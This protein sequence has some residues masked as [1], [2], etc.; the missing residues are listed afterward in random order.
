MKKKGFDFRTGEV[1]RRVEKVSTG[2]ITVRENAVSDRPRG[3]KLPEHETQ[4]AA[5]RVEANFS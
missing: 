2:T 1:A 5:L 3:T 4:A